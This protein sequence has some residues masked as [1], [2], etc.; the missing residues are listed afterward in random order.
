MKF[1]VGTKRLSLLAQD[2]K[3]IAVL[4]NDNTRPTPTKK[5]MECIPKEFKDSN[6]VVPKSKTL[7]IATGS[8]PPNSK[9]EIHS[10]A[11]SRDFS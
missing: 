8:H 7:I 11:G 9:K 6:I 3:S 5:I 2:K 10:I 1:P 4:I